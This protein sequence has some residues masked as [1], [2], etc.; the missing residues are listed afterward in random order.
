MCVRPD[1]RIR[2][3]A[4]DEEGAGHVVDPLHTA[5]ARLVLSP[6]QTHAWPNHACPTPCMHACAESR[7]PYEIIYYCYVQPR[8]PQA[9]IWFMVSTNCWLVQTSVHALGLQGRVGLRHPLSSF[10]TFPFLSP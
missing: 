5:H 1:L 9:E 2:W 6:M 4:S 8:G 7:I 3:E 10:Q